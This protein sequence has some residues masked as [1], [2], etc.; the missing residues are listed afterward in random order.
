[1]MKNSSSDDTMARVQRIRDER[2]K[3]FTR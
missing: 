2:A 3:R 1:M